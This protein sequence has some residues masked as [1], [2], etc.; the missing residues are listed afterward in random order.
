MALS[1]GRGPGVGQVARHARRVRHGS[2]H[3]PQRERAFPGSLTAHR[4]SRSRLA[5]CPGNLPVSSPWTG[6]VNGNSRSSRS[7]SEEVSGPAA[8]TGYCRPARMRG[9][10]SRLGAGAVIAPGNAPAGPAV[11]DD[12]DAA[13]GRRKAFIIPLGGDGPTR[14]GPRHPLRPEEAA[15][16]ATV[17]RRGSGEG[18]ICT[19]TSAPDRPGR[20][21]STK[22]T[23]NRK[24]KFMF[25]LLAFHHCNTTV[26]PRLYCRPLE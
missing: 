14:Q 22:S 2:F 9:P 18:L 15:S 1:P 3:A 11:L 25:R 5:I 8:E 4:H 23:G 13:W 21:L 10:V 6:P 16:G 20:P 17:L 7:G 26:G 19:G 12:A 24:V